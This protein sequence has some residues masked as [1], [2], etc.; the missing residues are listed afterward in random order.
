MP[1]VDPASHAQLEDLVDLLDGRAVRH[2][3]QGLRAALYTGVG[4]AY[5]QHARRD[6]D[7]AFKVGG[8]RV[9][10]AFGLY[11]AGKTLD[12]LL[13]GL[14]TRWKAATLYQRGGVVRP[15]R[16]RFLVVP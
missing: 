5:K 4:K 13:L 10:G 6:L 1:A 9:A 11:T 3:H 12:T 8:A 2:L 16:G 14:F 15:Q 7:D